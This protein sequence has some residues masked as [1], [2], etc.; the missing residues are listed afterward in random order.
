VSEFDRWGEPF[1]D[2]VTRILVGDLA[3]RLPKAQVFKADS[4]TATRPA[5]A[6]L[7]IDFSRFD[8][9]PDGTIVLVARW[10]LTAANGVIE[11]SNRLTAKPGSDSDADIVAAMS[12][13]LGQLA[14]KI[15]ARA[16]R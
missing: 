8:P 6:T 5:A 15:A 4:P 11:D 16:V 2:I 10:T 12:Q 7:Q 13:A 3:Q 14:D 1:G 9:D